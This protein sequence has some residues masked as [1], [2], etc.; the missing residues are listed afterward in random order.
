MILLL[1]S[2]TAGA[3]Y[4]FFLYRGQGSE[5]ASGKEITVY[6]VR[7]VEHEET[8]EVSGNVEPVKE[9]ELAFHTSGL[10]SKVYVREGMYVRGGKLLA[11]MDNSEQL[12][13]LEQVDY[14]IKE[15]ELEGAKR[16][17]E[18]LKMEKKL[19]EKKLEDLKLYTPISGLVSV[20]N[21]EEGDFVGANSKT[22][23][24][25]VIDTSKL[26]ATVEVDEVDA[27]EVKLGQKVLFHFDAF[28]DMEV[29][30]RVSKIPIEGTV[31]N[32]GIAVLN[33]EILIDKPPKELHPGFS[34]TAEIIVKPAEKILVVNRDAILERNGRKLVFPATSVPGAR[35]APGNATGN[36][37]GNTTRNATKRTSPS[38]ETGKSIPQG[39]ARNAGQRFP[40]PV[41]VEVEGYNDKEVR[42]IS[43]VSKG[44][45]LLSVSELMSKI[46]GRQN[47]RAGKNP[48]SIFGFPSRRVP[49]ATRRPSDG[50][51]RTGSQEKR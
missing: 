6:T 18:L 27:P 41:R 7:E 21:M 26:K 2:G 8:V 15:K 14:Q 19:K 49:G 9:K 3:L 31:T 32:E 20:V 1:L 22:A 38:S 23:V 44:D 11:E 48:L 40:R 39:N 46:Q 25:R 34:F 4:Y 42:V 29:T 43:G 10:V 51:T 5:K 28:P 16:E 13:E 12:Y 36:A 30:G 47:E 17:I 33:T 24:I 50:R 35:N 37:A 45:R